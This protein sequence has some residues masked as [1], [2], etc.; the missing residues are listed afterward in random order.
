MFCERFKQKHYQIAEQAINCYLSV[1]KNLVE[2]LHRQNS[3]GKSPKETQLSQL[4]A[5]LQ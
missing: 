4:R 1:L 2:H 5:L 3:D